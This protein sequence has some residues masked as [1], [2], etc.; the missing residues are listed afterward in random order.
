MVAA[1]DPTT[2]APVQPK[3]RVLVVDDNQDAAKSLATLL[4][5]WGHDCRVSY[6]GVD[7]LQQAQDYRPD[8]LLL[9]I[10][11]PGLDGCA[12]A[13][14]LRQQPDLSRVKLVAVTAY[15][16]ERNARRIREA[17][18]DHHVVKPADTDA[19]Q[20]LL[21]MMNEVL[22]LASQMKELAQQN[23]ALAGETKELLPDVKEELGEV[24]EE[25]GEVKDQL[26]DVT[27]EVGELKQELRQ[28]KDDP[29][30]DE[31]GN[32]KG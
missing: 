30:K 4:R 24:K 21:S 8:C 18:F 20:R 13:R 9:D 31:P 15:S 1:G 10:H 17:G 22:Q 12:V 14:R 29:T 7:A 16:D 32:A 6:D 3:L 27:E 2:G 25:L 26:E 23:V 19:L 28:V 11:M 5:L